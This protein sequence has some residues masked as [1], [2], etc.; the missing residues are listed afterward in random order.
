MSDLDGSEHA[1]EDAQLVE[2]RVFQ[3]DGAEPL[4][5]RQARAAAEVR[6]A[7]RAALY[8]L[9]EVVAQHFGFR[10]FAVEIDVQSRGLSRRIITDTDLH[11]LLCGDDGSRAD[12]EGV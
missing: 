7:E 12:G 10:R 5:D 9:G 11:P 8:I 6:H 4:A 2:E 1:V 3:A